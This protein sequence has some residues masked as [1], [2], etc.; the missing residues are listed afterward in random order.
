MGVGPASVPAESL[1]L[2]CI[3][4][5]QEAGWLVGEQRLQQSSAG[6]VILLD[7]HIG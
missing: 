1:I 3:L 5:T 4:S 7:L 6:L 2:P